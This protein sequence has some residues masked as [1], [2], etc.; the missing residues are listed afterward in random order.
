MRVVAGG[1]LF[2]VC[3]GK[4][5]RRFDGGE[6]CKEGLVG[7]VGGEVVEEVEGSNLALEGQNFGKGLLG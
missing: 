1:L 6:G 4:D 2:L 3:G 7:G 5:R